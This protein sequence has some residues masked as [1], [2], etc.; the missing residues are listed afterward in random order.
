MAE[1]ITF[2]LLF[3]AAIALIVFYTVPAFAATPGTWEGT[4][5]GYTFEIKVNAAGT[6]ISQLMLRWSGF[7]CGPVTYVSGSETHGSTWSITNSTFSIRI[8]RN[9]NE[10]MTVSGTFNSASQASGTL[11]AEVHGSVCTDNWTGSTAGV[12]VHTFSVSKSGSGSGTVTSSPSGINCGSTCSASFASGTSVTLSA[13]PASGSAFAGWSGS[14]SGSICTVNMTQ[15]RS[16]TA[17]F[18]ASSTTN[19]TPA[20][21]GLWYYPEQSGHG[22]SI[23]VHSATSATVFW[24]TYNPFG[25][26]IWLFGTGD[27]VGNRIESAVLY[28][29]GME[30]GT[31]DLSAKKVWEWGS[32]VIEF[33]SCDSATLTYDSHLKYD[34]GEEFGSGTLPLVRLASIDGLE[35]Q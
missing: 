29:N 18:N 28:I 8:N 24:Y 4:G 22:F 1:R 11:K 6:G 14:C 15:A 3:V 33:H 7:S 13:N 32:F 5:S 2:R 26:P 27:I 31:W 16:V 34:S 10:A 17:L 21:S 25:T 20:Y 9:S 23:S 30:F 19:V 12:T 35:C